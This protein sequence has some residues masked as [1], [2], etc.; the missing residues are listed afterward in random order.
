FFDE[1]REIKVDALR[2]A[3]AC[4]AGLQDLFDGAHQT[5]GVL[6]HQLIKAAALGFINLRFAALEGLQVQADGGDGSFQLVGDGIDEAVMLL[7]AANLA[8]QKTGV[9]NEAGGDSAEKDDAEKDLN[10]VL[11]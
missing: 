7:V 9:E 8:D 3:C 2:S 10:V 1:L 4:F 11:P 6:E 5:V